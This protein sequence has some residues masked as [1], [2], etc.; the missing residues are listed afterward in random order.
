MADRLVPYG[1]LGRPKLLAPDIWIVDG[2]EIA[3]RYGPAS[4]PFTTRMTVIRIGGQL[5]LHSP[6]AL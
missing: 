6:V 2:P 4:V 3:M 1:P 5:I